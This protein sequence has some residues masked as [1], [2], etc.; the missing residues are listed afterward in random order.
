MIFKDP[1]DVEDQKA[2]SL[3]SA[4]LALAYFKHKGSVSK[5]AKEVGIS[6]KKAETLLSPDTPDQEDKL[7]KLLEQVYQ[8][9]EI[10]LEK[11]VARLWEEANYPHKG[12]AGHRAVNLKA[13]ELLAKMQGAFIETKRSEISVV[14]Q[15]S[16]KLKEVWEERFGGEKEKREIIE[17][18]KMKEVQVEEVKGGEQV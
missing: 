5:A 10:T 3:Q 16:T 15:V 12:N 7:K 13:L 17:V 11:V 18:N 6:V 8:N 9:S 2:E 1:N 4:K 14:H